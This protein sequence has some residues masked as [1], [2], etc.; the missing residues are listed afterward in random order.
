[1]TNVPDF[2][3]G[4]YKSMPTTGKKWEC[5]ILNSFTVG[6]LGK[7]CALTADVVCAFSDLLSFD[8][9]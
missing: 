7:V 6:H 1:M 3:L 8:L 9:D 2:F 5:L 4:R